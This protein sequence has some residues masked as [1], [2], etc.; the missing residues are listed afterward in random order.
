MK[1]IKTIEKAVLDEGPAFFDIET[2]GL[3]AR[4][5]NVYLI[6]LMRKEGNDT[7]LTQ[8]LCE[9]LD[10]EKEML[11]T[12]VSALREDETLIHYNGAGFDI[13]YLNKKFKH[14]SIAFEIIPEKTRDLYKE[15]LHFKKYFPTD[16]IKLKTM[17]AAAGFA[18]EDKYDGAELIKLYSTLLGRF[19]LASIT[20]KKEDEDSANSLLREILLHNSDDIEGLYDI[21]LKTNIQAALSGYLDFSPEITPFEL[22]LSYN[23]PLFP[24]D[25][26]LAFS[27]VNLGN[28]AHGCEISIPVKETTLKYF[29]PDYRNYTYVID[30]DMC[31]HNSVVS[32][33]SK[34]NKKKCTKETAYIK[35]AGRYI[36]IPAAMVDSLGGYGLHLFKESYED[37]IFYAEL[38]DNREFFKEYAKYILKEL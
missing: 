5:S 26:E 30:R 1:I 37:K 18:R 38:K 34:D 7:V 27:G 29:F 13:P 4:T 6:G 22:I 2:T 9:S 23:V 21:Y 8:Y 32:G 14:Y 19:R 33:I 36:P 25:L 20:G 24:L 11:E 17:E 35:K 12:F 31:M 16:N 10:E 15:L 3:S 28:N